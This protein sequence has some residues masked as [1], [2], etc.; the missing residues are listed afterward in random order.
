M[1]SL[2]DSEVG[3]IPFCFTKFIWLANN[4]TRKDG[5]TNAF[6]RCWAAFLLVKQ[7]SVIPKE[8]NSSDLNQILGYKQC[9]PWA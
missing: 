1:T 7:A 5:C 3:L 8:R 2:V 4:N 6:I 9:R